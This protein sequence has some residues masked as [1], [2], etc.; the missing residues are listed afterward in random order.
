[1]SSPFG[2]AW[3]TNGPNALPSAHVDG[4]AN[5][6]AVSSTGTPTV[7]SATSPFCFPTQPKQTVWGSAWTAQPQTA[8][9]STG[10]SAS[11]FSP[12][13]PKT[14]FGPM[15][16][17]GARTSTHFADTVAGFRPGYSGSTTV[18]PFATAE[19]PATRAS[20]PSST[21]P[22]F[23]DDGLALIRRQAPIPQQPP[24]S[25]SNAWASWTFP[26][27][28]SAE[29]K[30]RS[31]WTFPSTT[32]PAEVKVPQSTWTFPTSTSNPGSG[33][34]GNTNASSGANN[35]FQFKWTPS[36]P[37]VSAGAV[38]TTA[39]TWKSQQPAKPAPM[40]LIAKAD[41][42][43]YGAGSFGAGLVEQQ[44]N[45][46][47]GSTSSG[48]NRIGYSRSS[49]SANEA[50]ATL[51]LIP[52]PRRRGPQ[53]LAKRVGLSPNATISRPK[54]PMMMLQRL[55]GSSR[56][57]WARSEFRRPGSLFHR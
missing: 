44:I 39:S 19:E 1:M 43:P 26:T 54:Q 12:A 33:V 48:N 42:D 16:S 11:P 21:W 35:G 50:V 15:L 5:P 37:S 23:H 4:R 30:P 24:L 13:A 52:A 20:P 9:P 45:E 57:S 32:T 3:S 25:Q 29:A 6:F 10:A 14:L 2:R 27:T 41:V 7:T 40:Y 31:E 49:K 8:Q 17:T 34:H 51:S 56:S 46:A 28:T 47:L 55:S 18:N 53:Q 36:A 38:A 22:H